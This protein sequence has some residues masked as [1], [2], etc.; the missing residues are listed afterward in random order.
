MARA[1]PSE[2]DIMHA[3]L[4]TVGSRPD[5]RLWRNNVGAAHITNRWMRFGLKG[6]SDLLG[7]LRGG[8]FL[9]IEVK[10]ATGKQS[11]AQRAFQKTITRFGGLYVLA[12]SIDDVTEALSAEGHPPP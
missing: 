1:T 7:L 2:A 4:L 8:R 10:S 5:V 3:I 9:A 6:S 11:P 12:R